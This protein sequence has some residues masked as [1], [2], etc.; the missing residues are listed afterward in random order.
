MADLHPSIACPESGPGLY[1]VYILQSADGAYYVGQTSDLR[2]RLRK[3][4]L[5][6]G[7]KH[8]HDHVTPQLVYADPLVDLTA[9]VQRE[10]QLKRWS[11][12]KKA[13]LIRSD[14]DRLR[15]LSRSR[16]QPIVTGRAFPQTAKRVVYPREWGLQPRANALAN[17]RR[18]G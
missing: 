8:T 15:K 11:R 9:A 6:L 13:A 3:H 7:S 17:L 1:W 2:E 4:R 12:S 18:G 16:D 5:G 10:R 14:F